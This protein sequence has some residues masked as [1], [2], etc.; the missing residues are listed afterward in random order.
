M[1]LWIMILEVEIPLKFPGTTA[2][3]Y[4]RRREVLKKLPFVKYYMDEHHPDWYQKTIRLTTPL[5]IEFSKEATDFLLKYITIYVSP[6]F[7]SYQKVDTSYKQATTKTLDQLKEIIRCAEFFGCCSF[8]DCIGFVIAHKL[9]RLT[10]NE[11]NTFLDPQEGER[12]REWRSA[13]TR[14]RI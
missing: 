13:F 10:A 9:N 5:E 1:Y 3:S 8:M 7:A 11:V 2:L 12:Y 4:I 14:R 6:A